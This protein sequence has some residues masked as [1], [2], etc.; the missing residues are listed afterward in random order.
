MLPAAIV[1][2]SASASIVTSGAGAITI[3]GG[4]INFADAMALNAGSGNITLAGDAMTLPSFTAQT[5]GNVT[6]APYSASTTIGVNGGSGTL[7]I[8]SGILGD[9]SGESGITIGGGTGYSGNISVNDYS[10]PVPITYANGSGNVTVTNSGAMTVGE[11]VTTTGT[12][13]L[14]LS[15]DT[16]IT[17]NAPINTSGG[18][19]TL[20]ADNAGNGSGYIDVAGNITAHGGNI[21]MG[22]GSGSINAGTL[23]ADGTIDTPASGFCHRECGA[24]IWYLFRKL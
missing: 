19:V 3:S 9:I 10:W 2:N 20:N 8:T 1:T 21:I 6:F 4:N 23:N 14:T 16:N 17:V 18:G 13:L 24:D 11:A 7:L 12:G 15:A 5:T 22:G